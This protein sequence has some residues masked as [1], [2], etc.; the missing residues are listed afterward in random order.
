MSFR[1]DKTAPWQNPS[2]TSDQVDPHQPVDRSSWVLR[3]ELDLLSEANLA[4][5]QTA[6]LGANNVVFGW[7][8]HY[9]GGSSRS[10]IAFTS[11]EDYLRSIERA[12]PGDF[13]TLFSLDATRELAVLRVGD[14]CSTHTL[15]PDELSEVDVAGKWQSLSDV[16][17]DDDAAVLIIRQFV[18]PLTGTMEVKLNELPGT[19]DER[20]MA[21]DQELLWGRGEL[22]IFDQHLLDEDE[23]GMQSHRPAPGRVHAMLEAKRP[24]LEGTIPLG[25]AY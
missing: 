22:I 2:V 25:G 9:Y 1:P 13:F 16:L 21:F 17:A 6:F 24:S 3:P 8:Y 14:V 19:P 20:K 15:R 5:A 23:H 10:I 12:R 4:I 11:W 7:Q 18:G